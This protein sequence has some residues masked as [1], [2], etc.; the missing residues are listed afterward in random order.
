MAHHAKEVKKVR[1]ELKLLSSD[2]ERLQSPALNDLIKEAMRLHPV[3]AP[4]AIRE[5]HRDFRVD[6]ATIIP[7]GSVVFTPVFLLHRNPEHFDQPDE[8][9]PWRTIR[10]RFGTSG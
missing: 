10:C 1:G 7:K 2:Y 3:A 6:D 8:F 4:G 5:T 9:L